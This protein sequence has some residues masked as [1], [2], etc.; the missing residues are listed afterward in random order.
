M[1]ISAWML[2]SIICADMTMGAPRV[3]VAALC[4]VH[5]LLR[6][7]VPGNWLDS[8]HPVQEK[9]HELYDQDS[10]TPSAD[11]ASSTKP[12]GHDGGHQSIAA[13]DAGAAGEHCHA[14]GQ[15]ADFSRSWRSKGE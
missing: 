5:Q 6:E 7:R 14:S 8:C 1:V 10:P 4:D 12:D 13:S 11:N 2:D 3:N 9:P 15:L